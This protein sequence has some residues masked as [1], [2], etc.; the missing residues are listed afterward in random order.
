MNI[1]DFQSNLMTTRPVFNKY[2]IYAGSVIKIYKVYTLTRHV[3]HFATGLIVSVDATVIGYKF[4][5]NADDGVVSGYL[6][7]EDVYNEHTETDADYEFIFKID[8]C[9]D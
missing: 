1:K 6:Y 9:N 3:E 5:A 7:A 4:Y 2:N 8:K